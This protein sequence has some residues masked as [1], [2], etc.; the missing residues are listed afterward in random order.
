MGGW[1]KAGLARRRQ[2][3]LS[4]HG[5]L[6]APRIISLPQPN[7]SIHSDSSNRRREFLHKKTSLPQLSRFANLK[8]PSPEGL[9]QFRSACCP[10]SSPRLL[11]T[12][13]R[14]PN[15]CSN[16]SL[17]LHEPVK[18]SAAATPF[19]HALWPAWASRCRCCS[20]CGARKPSTAS[21]YGISTAS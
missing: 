16:C 7:N 8:R 6:E 12:W 19:K 17:V 2:V 18:A 15:R 14:N 13:S 1:Y 9:P 11:P 20:D 10:A 4:G 5:M 21:R 3:G